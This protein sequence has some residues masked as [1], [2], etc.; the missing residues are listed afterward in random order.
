VVEASRVGSYGPQREHFFPQELL[1][2]A[3]W[4]VMAPRGAFLPTRTPD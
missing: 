1:T 2:E 4:G 3:E